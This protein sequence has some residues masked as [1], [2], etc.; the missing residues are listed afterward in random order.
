MNCV[1]ICPGLAAT[2]VDYKK[3]GEHPIVTLPYEITEKLV[4]KGS[5]ITVTDVNGKELAR[6]E[7]RRIITKKEFPG[8]LLVQVKLDKKI[9]KHAVGIRVQEEM[10]VQEEVPD[11]TGIPDNAIICR[12]ER[13]TAGEI[14]SAIRNGV[15]D[16]NELKAINR[17]GMGAC[18]SKTCRPMVWGIFR[19][20]GVDL[21][22]TTDRID[23][24][25][26]VEVP[27]GTLAGAKGGKR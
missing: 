10:I 18:G 1:A 13:V 24:P 27:L 19:D 16:M 11:T 23:R 4:E 14:R 15:R 17:T 12:C 22:Q 6:V 21:K 8:T 5:T 25:L 2:L 26:F 3:D 9:A 20:E 7:V